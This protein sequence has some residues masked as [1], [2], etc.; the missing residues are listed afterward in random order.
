MVTSE[1]KTSRT[2]PNA[3]N[4][5]TGGDEGQS[6]GQ[7]QCIGLKGCN[8]GERQRGHVGS[9]TPSSTSASPWTGGGWIHFGWSSGQRGPTEQLFPAVPLNQAGGQPRPARLASPAPCPT[10]TQQTTDS[11]VVLWLARLGPN[12]PQRKSKND[13]TISKHK[14]RMRS[15]VNSEHCCPTSLGWPLQSTQQTQRAAQL[16]RPICV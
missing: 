9:G 6:K 13:V 5:Q 2:S 16:G 7:M 11:G 8:G 14:V 1:R 4:T 12:H 15:Y 10:N 3:M